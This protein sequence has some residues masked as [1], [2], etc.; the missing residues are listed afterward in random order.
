M[1]K[2]FFDSQ[3]VTEAIQDIVEMQ[4]EVL[5]FAQYGEFATIAEQRDNL[6]LLRAL[7]SKQKNM[8]FRCTLTDDPDAKRLLE[9]VLSHF[10]EFGHE[11][12]PDNPL[13][14]FDNVEADLDVIE[15]EL[16][17]CEKFGYFPGEEPGGETPPYQ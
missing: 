8:C 17:F 12:D 13:L 1:D 9:E 2:R 3:I 16:D 14:V 11:I 5:L 7:H 15:H 6:K 10:R 4:N